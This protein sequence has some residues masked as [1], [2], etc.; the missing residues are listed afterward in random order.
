MR[1]IMRSP[2]RA[3]SG[4][5]SGLFEV[6]LGTAAFF[7]AGW[8][9]SRMPL[10]ADRAFSIDTHLW[11]L[12]VAAGARILALSR[13]G[14][15][16]AGRTGAASAELVRVLQV[17]ALGAAAIVAATVLRKFDPSR[18]F[19]GLYAGLDV[20][21]LAGY[22]L[23]A[24]STARHQRKRGYDRAYVIIAGTGR[25]ARRHAAALREHPEWGL[26]VKGFLSEAPKLALEEVAG[27]KVLGN[28]D[29]LPGL[30]QKEVVDEVHFAVSR[31][32]LERLDAA[33]AA[34]DEVGVTVRVGLGLL[35]R[36]NARPGLETL[37]G[38]PMLTLA[39]APRDEAALAAK[40]ALDVLASATALL[41]LSP[42]LLVTALVVKL[43]SAGPAIFRQKRSGMNG[44]IFTL[45]KFRTM[46]ADAE[47]RKAELE[48]RNEMDGPVFKIKADPRITGP[49][50]ILRKLS[51]DEL[52]QL[53]NVLRGDMS[54]V[55]PRPALPAEVEKYER[56][57]RRRLSMRP[58][59]TCIWQVSGRNTVD[60]KRW[61]EMDLE[62]IDSWS[63]G[64]D[65][66]L[67]LKTIPAVLFSRGAS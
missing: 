29:D 8:I 23:F 53:W 56:W 62:Y 65:L 22:R 59:I 40:R 21:L 48:S 51:I 41:L 6:L 57:Q 25:G 67:L 27:A 42:L 39:S 24:L 13:W 5:F 32:T 66:K 10:E 9:R 43:T 46:V 35:G 26:E 61:M 44:R 18:G 3:V 1:P 60:F 30:L 2:R 45:Y 47:A 12:P 28:L 7:L 34:C 50:R 36:L 52:P 11:L 17:V 14:F 58:G 4:L 33:L 37:E 19:L 49:G 38:L 63:L 20:L 54:L 55:G 15:H 64:L 16:R 31:R